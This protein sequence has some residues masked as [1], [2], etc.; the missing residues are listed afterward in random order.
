MAGVAAARPVKPM[1][2]SWFGVCAADL[3][4]AVRIRVEQLPLQRSL[5]LRCLPDIRWRRFTG[6]SLALSF[7]VAVCHLA[8]IRTPNEVEVAWLPLYQA[9]GPRPRLSFR[10]D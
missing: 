5:G 3:D 1:V 9:A 10:T 2:G 4:N 8:T 7:T 6:Y